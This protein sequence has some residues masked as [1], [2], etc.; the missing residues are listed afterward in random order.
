MGAT[1]VERRAGSGPD[2]RPTVP[3][4]RLRQRL[5]PAAETRIGLVVAPS[6]YGKTTFLRDWSSHD[7]RPCLWLDLRPEHALPARLLEAVSHRLSGALRTH[8][9][10]ALVL[11]DAAPL[12]AP[13]AE[14]LL[15]VAEQLPTGSI[16]VISSTCEPPLPVGRLRLERR[17]R[18]VRAA[19]LAMTAI[20]SQ[21]LLQRS[22]L[23]LDTEQVGAVMHATEGWPA[24]LA[25]AA[26]ALRGDGG[27]PA[28][29]DRFGG[30]DRIVADYLRDSFLRALPLDHHQLL[31]RTSIVE[32]LT[33]P[34]CD[35]I[36]GR[37]GTG[38][39]LRELAR[40]NLPIQDVVRDEQAFRLH[41]LL[42]DL[43]RAELRRAGDDLERRCHREAARWFEA[44]AAPEQAAAHA[45]AA[46]DLPR[47]GRLLW[48]HARDAT[49]RGQESEV[50]AC[51][52]H[53]TTAELATDPGLALSA[54]V[55]SL[56]DGDQDAAAHWTAV[57][58][59][60]LP[61]DQ[62]AD[63]T[64]A[65]GAGVAVLRAALGADGLARRA[66]AARRGRALARGSGAWRALASFLV[67]VAHHLA[68]ESAA[69]RP[70]LA[71]GARAGAVE[72]PVAAVLCHGQLALADLLDEAWDDGAAHADHAR[73]CALAHKLGDHP[74]CAL[75]LATCAFAWA[76]L[77]RVD[78]AHEA[79]AQTRRLL[80]AVE[81]W[82]PWFG[83]EVHVALARAELRLSDAAAARERL[84]A[85]GRLLRQCP[86]AV[87]VRAAI[88]DAWARADGFAA[89]T[90]AGV[91]PLTTAELRVMRML[92]SHL[93]LGEIAQ[94][95]HVSPNTVKTQAHAVYRKLDARS[96]SEAVTRARAVGLIDR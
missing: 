64:A 24:G 77:G 54:A 23:A 31:V 13:S 42:R 88:D 35:A 53:L 25:L 28:P 94:R 3:R 95:L 12:S 74:A 18:E 80:G 59:A 71:E 10:Q 60:A 2:P 1:L 82:P 92:P 51:L 9:P 70:P 65:L 63:G 85:A 6:G 43:L 93:S 87:T 90:T 76:H 20:E 33:G 30:Q 61:R 47:A 75:A 37:H 48:T 69:A 45:A 91:S 41:P 19:D 67:G 66:A 21:R 49:L 5:E 96:R 58:E 7:P 56:M 83:A 62:D 46:G 78:D 17:L 72:A 27:P 26:L 50:D 44:H 14:L 81:G 73:H 40:T 79:V 4:P 89:A 55:C 34:L 68:G 32:I 39:T 11:D 29:V 57:A 86:D 22:G 52:R 36:V 8:R 84:R 15:L 38:A 16:I